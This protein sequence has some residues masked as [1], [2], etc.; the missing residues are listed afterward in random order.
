[1]CHMHTLDNKRKKVEI[2]TTVWQHN[3]DNYTYSNN[4]SKKRK[5]RRKEKMCHV[6]IRRHAVVP[7]G[8]ALKRGRSLCL[9]VIW[10]LAGRGRGGGRKKQMKDPAAVPSFWV[11]SSTRMPLVGVAV[12]TAVRNKALLCAIRFRVATRFLLAASFQRKKRDFVFVIV[13]CK[14]VVPSSFVRR[15]LCTAI[16]DCRHGNN[17]QCCGAGAGNYVT[18]LLHN[19]RHQRKIL[20]SQHSPPPPPC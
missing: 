9:Q 6:C 14:Y 4:L 16:D 5:E 17:V 15:V 19:S 13:Q 8:R 3:R 2:A 11:V 12:D 18:M 7:C 1:M 20:H 10:L